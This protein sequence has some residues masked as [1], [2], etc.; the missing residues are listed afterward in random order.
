MPRKIVEKVSD[1]QLQKDLK[2]YQQR[3]LELGA[4]DAEIITADM[5]LVDERVAIKCLIPPCHRYGSCANCPPYAMEPEQTRKVVSKYRYAIF[6]RIKVPS[7]KIAGVEAK[8][9]R[10]YSP[11]YRKTFEIVGRIESEAFYDGYYLAMGFACGSCKSVFCPNIDCDALTQGGTCR[12]PLKARPSM[13]AVGINAYAMA[14]KIGWDIYPIGVSISPAEV[15]SGS[16]L[17][18]V[19]IY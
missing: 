15:P 2:K 13:E 7:R 16:A 11:S 5:V 14:A 17:G 18:L 1:A 4:T 10:L 8:Q 9:K 3:A 12:Y 19:L 6:T